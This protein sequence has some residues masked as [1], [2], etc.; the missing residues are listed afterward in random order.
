[1]YQHALSANGSGSKVTVKMVEKEY[2]LERFVPPSLAESMKKKEMQ[3]LLG[4]FI[5]L[6]SSLLGPGTLFILS[7]LA[8]GTCEFPLFS[9]FS[10]YFMNIQLCIKLRLFRKVT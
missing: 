5:K 10:F 7:R 8:N 1:M 4:H 3:K 6:N 2:G 9:S